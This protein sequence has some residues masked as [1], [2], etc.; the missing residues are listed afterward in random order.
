MMKRVAGFGVCFVAAAVAGCQ[1]GGAGAATAVTQ[2]A[3]AR[4]ADG[5]YTV[6]WTG[7][8][9]TT[10]VDVYVATVP[11][12]GPEARKQI[13]DND[14]DG[15]APVPAE[16]LPANGRLY[17]YVQADGGAGLWVGE[18]VLP[19]Q[20]G[21]NFRDLGGYRTADGSAVKWGQLYRSGVMNGLTD[22]DNA[23][24]RGLGITQI[25][26]FR[27]SEERADEPTRY[28]ALGT[29][30]YNA[31]DYTD[32]TSSQL[33]DVFTSPDLSGTKVRDAMIGLY[34]GMTE[35]FE[36]QYKDMF[37]RLV[38]GKAPLA[39]NCSAGKD[40]TGIAAA[41]VLSALGVPRA[42]ILEDYALSD[43]VVDY[44]A[45]Y[46]AQGNAP[47]AKEDGPYAFLAKLPADVRAPLLKSDPAYL[48]AA[49]KQIETKYGSVDAYLEQR[50]GVG[51][52]EMTAM[53]AQ[54]LE[55]PV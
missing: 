20:G 11:N 47:A 14:T 33:R 31:I 6:T 9:A 55:K 22:A 52:A 43:K 49:F 25:C 50:L 1:D 18:R 54:Y 17:V 5:G 46:Q 53:R 40:R 27:S 29:V 13:A 48:E 24:L 2:A 3:V 36:P 45:A 7:G 39:F 51:A 15:T 32:A 16:S 30:A 35:R 8:G 12:A 28:E 41:L 37:A 26:D 34:G 38:A 23:Y 44:E 19:L 42:T 4:A 10:P 21:R